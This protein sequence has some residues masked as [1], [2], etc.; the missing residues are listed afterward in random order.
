MRFWKLFL[1]VIVFGAMFLFAPI[2]F[3]YQD[4]TLCMP[5]DPSLPP[6]Q[7]PKCPQKGDLGLGPSFFRLIMWELHKSKE[8]IPPPP[9]NPVNSTKNLWIL[10]KQ[11]GGTWLKNYLECENI[12]RD[13]CNRLGGSFNECDSPCRH[14]TS[15]D[16]CITLCVR[17]CTIH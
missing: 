9:T 7:C 12:D 11:S 4:Q 16:L 8:I 2:P 6:S 15:A 5:C 13:V 3:V 14:D 1:G 17:V 10:C